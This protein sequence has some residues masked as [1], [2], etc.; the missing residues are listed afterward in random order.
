MLRVLTLATLFPDSGRLDFGRFV[1]RQT[2][3]LAAREGVEVAVVAPIGLPAWPLSRHRHYAA[4]TRLPEREAFEGLRVSRPRFRVW[5]RIGEAGAARAMAASVL[6]LARSLAPHVIDA[7]FFWPDG[8]A[9]MHVARALGIPFSVKA[10][11][12]DIAYWGRRP[13]VRR[14][15]L[16]AAEAAGGLLAVSAALIRD[17]AALGMAE[18]RIAVHHTGIDLDRFRPGDRAAAKARL[19]VTGPL[20]ASVGALVPVKGQALAIAALAH[21]PEATLILAGD[22]PERAQL[23]AEARRLGVAA[24]VRFAGAVAHADLP[25][26]LQAAD[27]MVL[28]SEREGLANAWVEALACGTPLVI[29]DVGGAREV[30]DR[31]AAGRIA[32]REPAAIAAAVRDIL[33]QPP[34]PEEVRAAAARFSWEANGAALHAHLAALVRDTR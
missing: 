1:L 16:E 14:Q 13:Q 19:G 15:M 21:L 25:P 12:S 24:R 26:L 6:P 4:R 2:Q 31:P 23:E 8:V 33:G 22:G 32:A 34:A 17:M 5:P 7:E 30:L 29:P 11:G 28:P 9:A 10:R 27:A 3:A 20:L 18:E